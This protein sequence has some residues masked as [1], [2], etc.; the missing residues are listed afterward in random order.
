MPRCIPTVLLLYYV[1]SLCC[2]PSDLFLHPNFVSALLSDLFGLQCRS[3]EVDLESDPISLDELGIA[4]R[5]A[6]RLLHVALEGKRRRKIFVP[7]YVRLDLPWYVSEKEV[8]AIDECNVEKFEAHTFI[9]V[10]CPP[11]A[12]RA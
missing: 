10:L 2:I 9:P 12:P 4:P 6:D 3:I 8:R 11:P 1:V 5:F 7:G